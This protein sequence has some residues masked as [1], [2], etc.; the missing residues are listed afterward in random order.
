MAYA[1]RQPRSPGIGIVICEPFAE[2]NLW[3][4]RPL[5]NLARALSEEGYWVLAPNCHGNGDS[6]GRF[7]DST[8]ETRLADIQTAAA[9]LK[10]WAPVGVSGFFGLRF[11][12]AGRPRGARTGTPADLLWNPILHGERYFL[13][14]L[15]KPRHPD[16]ERSSKPGT[17]GRSC[18]A[19]LDRRLPD[20]RDLS[21]DG[22]DRSACG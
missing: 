18:W 15:V 5:V 2:E 16:D 12:G 14:C 8:V 1:P 22:Q 3:A 6:A 11:G 10:A 20:C 9:F 21:P 4:Q 13:E 7:E 17:D 19:R